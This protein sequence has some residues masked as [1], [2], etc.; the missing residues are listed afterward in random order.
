MLPLAK[1]LLGSMT[2]K[3]LFR[4]AKIMAKGEP[5]LDKRFDREKKPYFFVGLV[6]VR[7]PYQTDAK[8]KCDKYVHPGM[9]LAGTRR[10]G[11]HGVLYDLIRYPAESGD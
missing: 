11:E 8:S 9:Q 5:G 3:A 2:P 10:F 1:G 6:C 7:E 4:F